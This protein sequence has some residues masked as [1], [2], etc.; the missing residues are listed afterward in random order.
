MGF[1]TAVPTYKRIDADP[2]AFFEPEEVK[3]AKDYQRPLTVARAVSFVA[4]HA[5]CCSSSSRRT[6]RRS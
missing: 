1:P 2:A 6:Q 3:K 5:A 4:E